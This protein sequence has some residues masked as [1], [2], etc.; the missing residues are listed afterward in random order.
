MIRIAF[1]VIAVFLL[2]IGIATPAHA[3]HVRGRVVDPQDKPAAGIQV[4]IVRGKTV[5]AT[6]TTTTDGQFGPVTV[7]A[8]DY[9]VLAAAA[10]LRAPATRIT[11]AAT[12][13]IEVNVKLALSAVSDSVVISAAQVDQP[14][15]RVTDSVTIIDRADLDARQTETAT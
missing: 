4:L 3:D 2:A 12:G 14:L 6:A 13:I 11:V 9:D 10:G 7:P 1:P 8:G 15:S 5:V